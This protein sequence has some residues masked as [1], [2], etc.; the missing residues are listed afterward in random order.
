MDNKK[1]IVY[2]ENMLTKVKSAY[3]QEPVSERNEEYINFAK[4]ELDAVKEKGL[5]GLKA[6][7]RKMDMLNNFNHPSLSDKTTNSL[8]FSYDLGDSQDA[9][10][11]QNKVSTHLETLNITASIV[12]NND[13]SEFTG[14]DEEWSVVDVEVKIENLEH[15]V[16]DNFLNLVSQV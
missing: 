15:C 14:T 6:Y 2:Y 13:E 7:W 5:E 16:L 10:R 4:G 9:Q 3:G 8:I 11:F 1:L 12:V